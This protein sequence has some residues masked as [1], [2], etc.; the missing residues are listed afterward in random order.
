MV[1][2]AFKVQTRVWVELSYRSHIASCAETRGPLFSLVLR[3]RDGCGHVVC[4]LVGLSHKASAGSLDQA[5]P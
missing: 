5:V 4:A 2:C 3:L 1:F